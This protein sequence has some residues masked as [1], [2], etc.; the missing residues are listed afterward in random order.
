MAARTLTA[1]PWTATNPR[2]HHQGSVH[3]SWHFNSGATKLGTASDVVLVAKIP[4]GVEIIEGWMRNTTKASEQQILRMELQ[5]SS[6]TQ[7]AVIFGTT[8]ISA[9]GGTVVTRVGAGVDLPY[10][11]SLSD[12]H[13][14]QYARLVAEFV[15]GTETVSH[16][17]AGVITYSRN[18]RIP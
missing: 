16:S 3:V 13:A 17:F 10:K 1:T 5:D 6:G 18:S 8:T 7:I 14:L 4:T 15:S 9:T 11:L 12:D 2:D